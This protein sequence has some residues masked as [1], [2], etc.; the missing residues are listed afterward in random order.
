MDIN[1]LCLG[2][3]HELQNKEQ[4]NNCPYCGYDLKNAKSSP[5]QLQPSTILMGKYL[6][7]K[8]IGEGGFG[9]TYL[10]FDLSLEIPV[11]IKEFY[12]NGFVTREAN[13]SPKIS[14]Y[15]GNNASDIEKWRDN[16]IKEARSLAKFSNL[17][18]IVKVHEFFNEN[19][20]AYIVMEFIDGITVK[21]YLK[22]NGGKL[23]VNQV[24]GMM[25][26][27]IQS[28][29]QVHKTG[30]IHRDISPDNIMITS[31]GEMK[32]LDFGAARDV[33]GSAEKSLSVMLK[34]G[35][36]PEEQYRTRG[37]QGTWSDVYALCATIYKC[38]TGV[39]PIESMERMRM[40]GLKRP[41]E[42]G[43]V[44]EPYQEQALMAGLAVYADQRIQNMGS[45]HDALYTPRGVQQQ[46]SYSND[47]VTV[48]LTSE[49]IQNRTQMQNQMNAS[50]Q[51]EN[52]TQYGNQSQFGGVQTQY[53][54]QSQFGNTQNQFVSPTQLGTGQ[55]QPGIAKSPHGLSNAMIAM[56]GG[57]VVL[58]LVSIILVVTLSTGNKKKGL[59]KENVV[60]KV[61]QE[62]SEEKK[63]ETAQEDD[64]LSYLRDM[65]NAN[66][67][68]SLIDEIANADERQFADCKDQVNDL[69][70]E[71]IEGHKR[72]CY[73]KADEI[74]ASGDLRGI[75][76]L[77]NAEIVYVDSLSERGIPSE[78]LSTED[79]YDKV[80]EILPVY[81]NFVFGMASKYANELDEQG[82]YDLFAEAD[83]IFSDEEYKIQ[84]AN[85]FAK[86]VAK[87]ALNMEGTQGQRAAMDYINRNLVDTNYNGYVMEVWD[88]LDHNRGEGS[89]KIET[90]HVPE[91]GYLLMG[92]DSR[93]IDVS[94]LT[95]LTRY[96]VHLAQ[97]EIYA[98]HGRTFTDPQ[99]MNYFKG[100]SWYNGS[101]GATAFDES[102]L[103]EYERKNIATIVGYRISRGWF[104]Y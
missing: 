88:V 96:E 25:E 11:A 43:I 73:Q 56:I 69:L 16:F 47:S 23:P 2:C 94:E 59:P 83:S 5:H 38:I 18:G 49:K 9:I 30:I 84:K 40:D 78:F 100:Q 37:N 58:G 65:L 80:S 1:N 19:N 55:P 92:S 64:E 24:L 61:E 17:S 44:M 48:P 32:L 95:Y 67:Y 10:G 27:V 22:Q 52:Q 28:L 13:V 104:G 31:N 45:L 21:S 71:A 82:W 14:I 90:P 26:P 4:M 85:V 63:E 76:P 99:F 93:Y 77:L 7:G 89:Y 87:N 35:Y 62:V 3:M 41:C 29:A 79:I 6:I 33:S 53:G 102:T 70:R 20:T 75:V 66:E 39:T 8:V 54:T 50:T 91:N 12:P 34:P 60:Q 15:A 81:K 86:F 72:V 101:I 74:V 68:E 36:A 57:A 51:Y 98:R 46:A 42:L 103:N 97:Y